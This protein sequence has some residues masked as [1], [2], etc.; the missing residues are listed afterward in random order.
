MS[1][2]R[3]TAAV[4]GLTAVGIAAVG[5]ITNFEGLRTHA[6]RDSIGVP[7]ICIG[8]TQN[9][10]MGDTKSA[11][12]CRAMLVRRLDVFEAGVRKC[13]KSPDTVPD[14]AYVA[15]ISLAYN[16]G[17]P[18]FC[19]SSIRRKLDAGD[20]RGACDAFLN[21]NKAG[22]HVIAGL[23]TRRKAERQICLNGLP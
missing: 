20:V 11:E 2:L 15:S 3:S 21:W 12:E 4:G 18:A 6:Y 13:L 16:V 5:I 17:V 1:R 23:T 8:E 10:R 14:G 19:G 7:T 22:G 9:V